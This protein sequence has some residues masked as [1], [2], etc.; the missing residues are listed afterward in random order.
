MINDKLA[1]R[2]GH[3]QELEKNESKVYG[4][5]DEVKEPYFLKYIIL[6]SPVF[7]NPGHYNA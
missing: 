7:Y 6:Y 3:F 4:N 1:T 2:A 5:K